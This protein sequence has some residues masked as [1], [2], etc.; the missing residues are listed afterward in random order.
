[1]SMA[2][3]LKSILNVQ[4]ERLALEKEKFKDQQTSGFLET[5]YYISMMIL[6]MVTV[7]AGLGNLAITARSAVQQEER[8]KVCK[9]KAQA[10]K[11]Q[12]EKKR[13]EEK[14]REEEKAKAQKSWFGW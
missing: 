7:L 2:Q 14:A 6:G 5:K 4:E 1:M 3:V 8:E 12:A 10:E 13:K 9:E 11:V